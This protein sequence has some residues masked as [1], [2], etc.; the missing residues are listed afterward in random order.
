VLVATDVAARGL[1][2]PSVEH[3]IHFQL[4]RSA[5]VYVHR[6][7]RTARAKKEGFSLQLVGPEERTVARAL[8]MSLGRSEFHSIARLFIWHL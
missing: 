6:N 8:L 1:D 5:D 3:V 4:P 2:I 7:G